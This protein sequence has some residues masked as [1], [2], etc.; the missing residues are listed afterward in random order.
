MKRFLST[1]A[2][3][4]ALAATA[5]G[6]GQ[7][8]D[9]N[10]ASATVTD[11]EGR[12]IAEVQITETPNGIH[13]TAEFEA[14]PPGAHAFHIHE[15]GQC[16]GD[17]GT[18]GGHFNPTGAAHGFYGSAGPHL[19]DMPNL[20]IPESGNLTVEAFVPEVAIAP[21][22]ETTLFD[23]D[24]SALVLHEGTDDYES[25]PSGA[26]GERIGCGAIERE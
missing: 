25:Q 10:Q 7:S 12:P 26:A 13:L 19:G 3:G 11:R 16:A 5:C 9:Q 17:F 6:D 18:A 21:D 14:A 20:H 8:Q 22:S 2:V 15:T 1:A 23:D 4:L 24:G